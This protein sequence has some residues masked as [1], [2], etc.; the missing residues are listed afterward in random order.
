M[1]LT[2]LPEHVQHQY[3]LQSHAK[4]GYVYLKIWR[5]IYILPQTGKS[6]NKYLREK[7]LPHG[8]YEMSHTPGFWKYISRPIDF[9]IVVD[10]FGVKY[11]GE[12]NAHHL[13]NSLK[14]EFTISGNWKGGLYCGIN[15]KWEYDKRTLDIS[16]PVYIKKQFAKVQTSAP[17]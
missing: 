11:V 2:D 5:Y 8:Y 16:M 9:C 12:Y 13:I 7:L 15:L 4:N 10:N 3:N 17:Q 6:E 14:E 1:K